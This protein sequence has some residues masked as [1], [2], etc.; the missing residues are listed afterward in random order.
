MPFKDK[1]K[2]AEYMRNRRAAGKV[3]RVNFPLTVN[4]N[5]GPNDSALK[6]KGNKTVDGEYSNEGW[7]ANCPVCK[8]PNIMD[9]QRSFKPKRSCVHFHQL[10]EPGKASAFLFNPKA[11]AIACDC[12]YKT[13][14][15]QKMQRHKEK[16]CPNKK[17]GLTPKVNVNLDVNPVNHVNLEEY[18]LCYSREKY[19]Y[20]FY[21]IEDGKK[22]LIGSKTKGSKIQLGNS[23]ITLTWGPE[24]IS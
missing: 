17:E 18:L 2:M 15:I 22:L 4:P 13:T 9:P 5:D 7:I 24:E 11:R 16:Y 12:S 8:N 14:D 10:L 21:K 23:S 20:T 6:S 19:Q 3:N 1:S